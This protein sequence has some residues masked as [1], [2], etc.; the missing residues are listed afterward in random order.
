MSEIMESWVNEET[1]KIRVANAISMIKV[2]KMT[3]EEIAL[4]SGLSV[5]EVKKLAEGESA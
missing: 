2:G 5:E 3:L 4:C 1:E